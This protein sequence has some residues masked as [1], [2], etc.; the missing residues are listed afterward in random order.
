MLGGWHSRWRTDY[1]CRKQYWR[2]DDRCFRAQ[3][4]VAVSLESYFVVINVSVLTIYV[5]VI[6]LCVRPRP[7]SFVN[8]M[9]GVYFHKR[10]KPLLG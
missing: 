5:R 8:G 6:V 3:I 2:R 4:I 7:R 9:S 1:T 10:S